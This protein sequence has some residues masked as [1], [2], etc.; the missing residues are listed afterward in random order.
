VESSTSFL[1]SVRICHRPRYAYR[2][3]FDLTLLQ[4][5]Q[6]STIL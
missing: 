3:Q 2:Y 5:A 1:L 4:L 6:T